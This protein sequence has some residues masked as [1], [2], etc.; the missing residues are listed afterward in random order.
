MLTVRKSADRGTADLGWL[1]SRHSFSYADY[2]DAQH[3][4]FGPLRVI[5]ED[6][7]RPGQGFGTHG[8]R[9]M[10]ILTLV[11]EG[12]LR[13]QDSMGNGS[14]IR[15]G[16]VQRMS[17]GTGVLHSEVNASADKPVHLIQIWILPDEER[18]TPEYEEREIDP[19]ET[20]GKLRLIASRDGRDGSLKVHQDTSLWLTTLRKGEAISHGLAPGRH[21]WL[22]V[23]RGTIALNGQD[24]ETGDG[25]A[26][27]DEL[28]L[29][30]EA[31]DDSEVLLF[32][33]A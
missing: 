31:N 27:S 5:N 2:Y 21:A 20:R 17:A 8:H 14:V 25:A 11:L 3:M 28:A 19:E 13:H 6:R 32:D 4:G 1:Y 16:R 10:E 15:R 29:T 33:L 23:A 7:V 9:D 18:L 26:V 24:L 22:Q 12:E 30:I